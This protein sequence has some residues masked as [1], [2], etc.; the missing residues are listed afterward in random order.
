MS[1]GAAILDRAGIFR[2]KPFHWAVIPSKE[3]KSVAVYVNSL[4]VSQFDGKEWVSWEES[5]PHTTG[6]YWYVIGKDGK[7][8][9]T[10][11]KQLVESGLWDGKLET[12]AEF[13]PPDI[14]VQLNVKA[15]EWNGKTTYKPA[16]MN[17]ENFVPNFDGATGDDLKVISNQ[18]G[19]L[20]RAVAASIKPKG[21]MPKPRPKGTASA[22]DD[23]PF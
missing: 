7:I 20:L 13:D 19:S 17:H 2:A 16:W 21:E 4:I 3:T 22:D 18:F 1:E 11:V 8:N 5:E 14:I 10:A 23:V 6:G 9:E 15:N 12:V